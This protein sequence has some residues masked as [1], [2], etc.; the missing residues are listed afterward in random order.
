MAQSGGIGINHKNMPIDMQADQ[1]RIGKKYE[2]G[3]IQDPYTV[4]PYTTIREVLELTRQHNIS[5]VPVVD[6]GE[7]VGIVTSCDIPLERRTHYRV[8][9]I[10]TRKDQLMTL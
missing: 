10:M 2:A 7:L 5:G 3:V 6:G 1:V 8:R 4:G 9:N